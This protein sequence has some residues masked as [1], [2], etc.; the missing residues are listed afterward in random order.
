MHLLFMAI[1]MPASA[2]KPLNAAY[3]SA[4]RFIIGDPNSTRHCTYYIKMTGGPLY[5]TD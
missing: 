2:F 3:H 5:L 1:Y 4:I